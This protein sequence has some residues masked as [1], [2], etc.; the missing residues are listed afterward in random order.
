MLASV[1]GKDKLTRTWPRHVCIPAVLLSGPSVVDTSVGR[2]ED[3]TESSVLLL[4]VP[5]CEMKLAGIWKMGWTFFS[6]KV[7]SPFTVL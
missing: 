5:T 1:R 7:L 3:S 4:E 6:T 2:R